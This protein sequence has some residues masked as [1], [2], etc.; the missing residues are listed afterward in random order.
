MNVKYLPKEAQEV[1][2][3]LNGQ[4]QSDQ[5]VTQQGQSDQNNQNP[6]PNEQ[7]PADN[8]FF[9]INPDFMKSHFPFTDLN[10]ANPDL[11]GKIRP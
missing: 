10:A 7:Q 9:R 3:P 8:S 2:E 6:Q 11:L 5:S 1:L 4:P